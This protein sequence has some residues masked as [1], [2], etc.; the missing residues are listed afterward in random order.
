MALSA[1][2][3]ELEREKEVLNL[4]GDELPHPDRVFRNSSIFPISHQG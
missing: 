1:L 3:V 2:P 4:D